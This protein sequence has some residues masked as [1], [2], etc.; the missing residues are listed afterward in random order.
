MINQD[1]V[2][3]L[4]NHQNFID[5]LKH[6]FIERVCFDIDTTPCFNP[7]AIPFDF[8]Y[9]YSVRVITNN[10]SF[11]IFTS[12]TESACE[13]FWIVTT[14]EHKKFS[15]HLDINSKVK[16]V[17]IKNDIDN[18]A[19]KITIEFEHSKLFIYC[20]EIYERANNIL[21]YIVGDE[22]ILVFESE[23]EAKI[24]ETLVYEGNILYRRTSDNIF[25]YCWLQIHKFTIY[26]KHR[27]KRNFC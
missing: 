14:T 23:K 25:L 4:N 8:R 5:S 19:F 12:Q 15:N 2:A 1:T 13:T 7:K 17:E 10:E 6:S 20:G 21:D 22:M 3:Y 11:D 26:L 16:C 24:F 27:F 18:Y 9:C